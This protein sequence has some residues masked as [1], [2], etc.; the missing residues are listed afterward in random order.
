MK[1]CDVPNTKREGK[2]EEVLQHTLS[3]TLGVI[4]PCY[5]PQRLPLGSLFRCW[6]Q[7]QFNK[8]IK[9]IPS[10]IISQ[11]LT[12]KGVWT[13]NSTA[14]VS[15]FEF[16]SRIGQLQ[17]ISGKLFGLGKPPVKK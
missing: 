14:V 16:P 17:T 9:V 3:Y 11:L 4:R 1:F 15:D 2:S 10:K 6:K 5:L 8:E 12:E 7:G 13:V